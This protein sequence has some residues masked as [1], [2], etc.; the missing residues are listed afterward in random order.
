[1]PRRSSASSPHP[2]PRRRA[3]RRGGGGVPPPVGPAGRRLLAALPL[4]P[5]GPRRSSTATAGRVPANRL[6]EALRARSS[7]WRDDV[8]GVQPGPPRRPARRAEGIVV[9]A[10]TLRR[11]LAEAGCQP[12]RTRRPA[13][14]PEPARADAPGGHAPPGRRQPPRLARGPGTGA[15][16]GRR[17]RRRHGARHGRDLPA[18]RRTPRATSRCSA[19]RAGHGLPL[20][21]YTDRHGI[22]WQGPQPRPT[23]AEQLTGRPSR[24]QVGRALDAAAIAWIGA[25]SPQAKGRVERLWGTAPGPPRRPSCGGRGG[26]PRGR[27]RASSPATCPATTA[28]SRSRRPNPEPAWR[29]LP[30]GPPPEAVFCFTYPRRVPATPR[31]AWTGGAL[32]L[33]GQPAGAGWRRRRSSSRSGSTA[34]CG[35]A[36]TGSSTRRAALPE[37]PGIPPRRAPASSASGQDSAAPPRPTIPGAAILRCDPGDKVAGRLAVR[38]WC[39]Q[40]YIAPWVS[41]WASLVAAS[42]IPAHEHSV[43]L[44]PASVNTLH[45]FGACPAPRSV[46]CPAGSGAVGPRKHGGPGL[47]TTQFA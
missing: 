42:A 25:R 35:P 11:I 36:S 1:M 16:P 4:G 18:T 29:P 28:A 20:A 15:D 2:C 43:V 41:A 44:L 17:H 31:S 46:L 38:C 33:L 34:A 23:L 19:R 37:R 26:D 24:T 7:S 8:R 5:R 32:M 21:L 47:T 45:S 22:F 12:P 27:Q 14:P 6:D 30:G 3:D 9:P 10:R 13:G 39:R 40:F